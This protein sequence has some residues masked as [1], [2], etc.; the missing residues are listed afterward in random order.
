[1]R[2]GEYTRCCIRGPFITLPEPALGDALEEL[3]PA[4]VPKRACDAV[5]PRPKAGPNR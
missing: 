4:L 1:M 2:D 3:Q 5:R